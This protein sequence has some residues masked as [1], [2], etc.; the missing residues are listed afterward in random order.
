MHLQ[1]DYFEAP[2]NPDQPIWR[3][4]DIIKLLD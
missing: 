2:S 4:L 1:Q 3:Y